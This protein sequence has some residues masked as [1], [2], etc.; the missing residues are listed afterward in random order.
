MKNIGTDDN[1]KP[2]TLTN[3]IKPVPCVQRELPGYAP[4]Q[5]DKVRGG[6]LSI[7]ARL[8]MGKCLTELYEICENQK[9]I[10]TA[11]LQDVVDRVSDRLKEESTYI[12]KQSD[13]LKA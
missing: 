9:T 13:R 6:L 11:K 5:V 8:V 10:N 2:A 4:S 7:A 3:L 12:R 1:G